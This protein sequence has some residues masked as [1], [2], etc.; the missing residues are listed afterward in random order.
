MCKASQFR[1]TYVLCFIMLYEF[2]I[3]QKKKK[4]K[5][6]VKLDDFS[7][8]TGVDTEIIHLKLIAFT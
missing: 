2:T 7:L 3:K 8:F 4:E 1:M 5:K 6:M